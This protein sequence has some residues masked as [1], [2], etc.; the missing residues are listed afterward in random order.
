MD[1]KL[2][3]RRRSL[4]LVMLLISL[5]LAC[6]A[7]FC[8]NF[9]Q[10]GAQRQ[11]KQLEK[12]WNTRQEELNKEMVDT[13]S[14]TVRS[15]V[16]NGYLFYVDFQKMAAEEPILTEEILIPNARN[17]VQSERWGAETIRDYTALSEAL[18]SSVALWK[19]DFLNMEAAGWDYVAEELEGGRTI[20]NIVDETVLNWIDGQM[21]QPGMSLE[22]GPYYD[23]YLIFRYDEAGELKL[24]GASNM[25]SEGI[26]RNIQSQRYRNML[27]NFYI[28]DGQPPE[29]TRPK[30]M[31]VFYGYTSPEVEEFFD[32]YWGSYYLYTDNGAD[33]LPFGIALLALLAAVGMGIWGRKRQV[34]GRGI[35]S[36]PMEGALVGFFL[37]VLLYTLSLEAL[38]Q[39]CNGMFLEEL[40]EQNFLESSANV[41][42]YGYNI[43]LWVLLSLVCMWSLLIVWPR[44]EGGLW[45]YLKERSLILRIFPACRRLYGAFYS[46]MTRFDIS[47]SIN[48]TLTKWVLVNLAILTVLCCAW[49]FGLPGLILYSIG[50]YL[51][52]RKYLGT[53]QQQYQTMLEAAK[54]MA[55]GNLNTEI[56]EDM[57]VFEPLK[58][59]L[60]K[61][62]DGF[63]AAVEK[64]VKSQRMKTEL[65]TNVSHDLKT[66]LTAIITYVDL[67]KGDGVT[68][69]ERVSYIHTLEKK[70]NRLK[71]LIE[72]L[73]EVSKAESQ[74]VTMHLESVD[75]VNLIKQ[76]CLEMEDKMEDSNL[77]FRWNLPQKKVIC[78]LDGQR[79]YRVFENLIGNVIKYSMEGSRVYMD[80]YETETQVQIELKNISATELNFDPEE[81]TERFVRGDL[82]R[83]TEGSGLGLAIARSFVELQ[84]GAFQ[85]EI[86]GDLFKVKIVFQRNTQEKQQETKEIKEEETPQN[87]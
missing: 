84:G 55:E 27:E 39:T 86:D 35:L 56:L 83:N 75:L 26:Y 71:V 59:Q 2:K 54:H 60:L 69:E 5:A 20:T 82:S 66:P 68:D 17:M 32:Q 72:D 80:L 34:L 45:S 46:Y 61:V 57:G 87:L 29:L 40:M 85:I 22:K 49:F 37:F 24:I 13:D 31:Q 50:L 33:L 36:F 62:Q 41:L 70:S 16:Q 23:G 14:Y 15:M 65:I 43:F 3:S 77:Q 47:E 30:N 9:I 38:V 76:V 10:T 11:L 25:D 8:Y 81:I 48:K 64:E 51:T 73:F 21:E 7:I 6:I 53:I 52:L 74:N 42:I 1:T 44:T 58:V 28:S 79:T 18:A 19:E 78:M 67:L 63:K 4:Y 12:E